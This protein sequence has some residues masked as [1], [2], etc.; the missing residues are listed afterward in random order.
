MLLATKKSQLNK[1]GTLGPEFEFNNCNTDS[2]KYKQ[3]FL[4][5]WL[6]PKSKMVLKKINFWLSIITIV[7]FYFSL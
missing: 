4:Q 6:N 2:N 5:S 7:D 1:L 3:R